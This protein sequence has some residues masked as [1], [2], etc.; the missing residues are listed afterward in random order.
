MLALIDWRILGHTPKATVYFAESSFG[1]E[2]A[3][4]SGN[5]DQSVALGPQHAT[6]S[7]GV[8]VRGVVPKTYWMRT[9]APWLVVATARKPSLDF[10]SRENQERE[11]QLDYTAGSCPSTGLIPSGQ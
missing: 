11:R 10:L 9:Q 2:A 1:Y 6:V 5:F 7:L 4:A 8:Q 3:V